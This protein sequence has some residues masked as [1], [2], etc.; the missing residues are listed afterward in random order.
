MSE[1]S[2]GEK[3][4]EIWFARTC[5]TFDFS[6]HLW[7]Q[8]LYFRLFELFSVRFDFLS[9]GSKRLPLLRG[10]RG[11]SC[12]RG[13]CNFNL[14]PDLFIRGLRLNP[15]FLQR[16]RDNHYWELSYFV[17]GQAFRY[18][19][20]I[21]SKREEKIRNP[22]L[23]ELALKAVV[24]LYLDIVSAGEQWRLDRREHVG[25]MNH[26]PLLGLD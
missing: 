15:D 6:L 11:T 1:L 24:Y 17:F 20:G 2:L 12:R 3:L 5:T 14:L 25:F 13:C 26:G 22:V 10:S 9:L 16:L 19:H 23:R 8:G 21:D 4:I 7:L 18:T